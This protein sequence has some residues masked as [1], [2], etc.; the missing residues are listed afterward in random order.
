M[1]ENQKDRFN[2]MYETG[3][4]P[5][6]LDRADADL[7]DLVLTLPLSP[8]KVLELG[9]GSGSNAI[10]LAEKGFEVYGADFSPLAIEKA[11]I[12]AGDAGVDI[13]FLEKDFLTDSIEIE[14]YDFLFDRGCFH[15]FDSLEDREQFAKNA[16]AHLK[17]GGRWL[18]FLGNADGKDR[19]DGPPVRSALDIALA[20]EPYFEILFLKSAF[21]DSEREEPA[22]NWQCLMQK[23]LK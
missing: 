1:A 15:S 4:T 7:V 5:W 11:K 19:E 14:G 17:T 22:R 23:R 2:T 20:V 12:K 3:Y 13:K 16:H 9:C 21:F 10:W 8:C 6:E 18:S